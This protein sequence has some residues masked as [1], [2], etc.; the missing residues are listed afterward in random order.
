MDFFFL[1]EGMEKDEYIAR[2]I[3]TINKLDW[4]ER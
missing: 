3:K 1:E 2:L 4:I